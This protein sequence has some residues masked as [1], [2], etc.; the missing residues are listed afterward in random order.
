MIGQNVGQLLILIQILVLSASPRWSLR[1]EDHRRCSHTVCEEAGGRDDPNRLL[2]ERLRP[3][4]PAALH[5]KPAAEM[6][7]Q[8]STL[9]QRQPAGQHLFLLQ[10]QDLG[11]CEGLHQR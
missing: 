8:H 1:P 9:H 3:H 2:P 6:R 11:L 5:G 7:P 10:Q 4:R